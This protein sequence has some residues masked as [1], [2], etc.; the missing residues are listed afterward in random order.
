MTEYISRESVLINCPN[1]AH[2]A[3]KAMPSADVVER[4]T[5]K[6]IDGVCSICNEGTDIVESKYF[7]YCPYCGAKMEFI[8]AEVEDGIF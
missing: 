8:E 3:I 5:G 2:D 7:N 6:W 1:V 4:K